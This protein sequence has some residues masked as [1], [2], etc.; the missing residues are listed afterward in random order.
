LS[1][2]R[3]INIGIAGLLAILV[4]GAQTPSSAHMHED[5]ISLP[6]R[7]P[8]PVVVRLLD[9]TV[10]IWDGKTA[11]MLQVFVGNTDDC[12]IGR[13]PVAGRYKLGNGALSFAPAFDFITGQDYVA[14]IRIPGLDEKLAGFSI[15]SRAGAVDA[16]VTAIYPSGDA[17]P[18][19]TLRFYFHFSVPM[20]P[21]VA[22]DHIKLRDA[23]GNADE[24]AF[25]K[26]KQELWDDNR[27]RLTVL[28]DP[29]RIKRNVATNLDL[30]PALIEGH[31]YTLSVDKGW[32]SADGSSYLPQFS[33]PFTV[34]EPLRE[35]P[36]IRFWQIS[37][38]C[39]GTREPLNITFDRPFD[40]HLLSKEIRVAEKNGRSVGGRIHIGERER[41]WSF[42][43]NESWSHKD[44]RVVANIGLEDVAGNNFRDLLDQQN[45]TPD[46]SVS[47]T[48]TTVR[49]KH[50][51]G[52][53][54]NNTP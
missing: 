39:L 35:R 47:I 13:T 37:S 45:G 1:T 26:F 11:E 2:R 51:T 9:D 23:S 28:I 7:G 8:D 10:D 49:L 25:M 33:K 31:R 18:E 21:H 24:A 20:S 16:S 15:P 53:A 54:R 17:L 22:F 40:R 48:K 5:R 6:Q 43:P 14:R 3:F 4:L 50:C 29:G 46:A 44:L 41:S 42:T 38:P 12:C 27:T 30:G 52:A 32:P 34:T 36:D 19:N